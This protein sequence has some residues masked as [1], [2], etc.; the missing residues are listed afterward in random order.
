M[1][2]AEQ[3][4][5]RAGRIGSSD[6]AAILGED[7]YRSASDVWA[8]KTGR[9]SCG[10]GNANTRRGTLLEPVILDWAEQELKRQI[11]RDVMVIHPSDLLAANL[12][13]II[14]DGPN[15]PEIVEGKSS[16]LSDEWGEPMT[17]EVPRRVIIQVHHQFAMVG[18]LCRIA[19]VPVLMPG[20]RSFDFRLYRIDRDDDL[21]DAVANAGIE[22]MQKHVIPDVAP[23]NYCPSVDVLKRVRREPNK[24][25]ELS[26]ELVSAYVDCQVRSKQADEQK[27]EAQRRILTALGD[28]EAGTFAGGRVTYLQ[29]TRK[30]YTVNESTFRVMR[31]GKK[32]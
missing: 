19:W 5:L 24:T 25:V 15:G 20:Y 23:E 14:E 31:V 29:Q 13:G 22:F 12:D 1:I 17:D 8:E 2:S 16:V 27:E 28:A 11:R 18:P 4:Q 21:A 32:K 30:S 9:V 6:A 7:A 26:E 3:K 10:D